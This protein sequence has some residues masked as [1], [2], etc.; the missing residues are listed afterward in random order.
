MLS[1]T[2]IILVNIVVVLNLTVTMARVTCDARVILTLLS[3]PL[4]STI[5]LAYSDSTWHAHRTRMEASAAATWGWKLFIWGRFQQLARRIITCFVFNKLRA[6]VSTMPIK[7]FTTFL[8]RI[9][10]NGLDSCI[11]VIA[12]FHILNYFNSSEYFVSKQ[13]VSSQDN[14][15]QNPKRYRQQCAGHNSRNKHVELQTNLKDKLWFRKM[16]YLGRVDIKRLKLKMGKKLVKRV[17]KVSDRLC[18]NQWVQRKEIL[19]GMVD[20]NINFEKHF[21]EKVELPLFNENKSKCSL[22]LYEL[23]LNI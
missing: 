11:V 18:V 20:V 16:L 19:Y 14:H 6:L 22:T 5:S 4:I 1:I 17:L 21:Y 7:W 2:R 8:S 12:H 15:C 9:I 13:P 23:I 3:I 10:V